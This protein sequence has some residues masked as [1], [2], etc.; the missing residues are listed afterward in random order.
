MHSLPGRV[1]GLG[2]LGVVEQDVICQEA[3]NHQ[4]PTI[5]HQPSTINF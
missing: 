4:P 2:L 3:V 1:L 5:N